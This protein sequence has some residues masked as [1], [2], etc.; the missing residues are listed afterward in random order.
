M[1]ERLDWIFQGGVFVPSV[2]VAPATSGMFPA[3]TTTRV[4]AVGDSLTQ[5]QGAE[6]TGGYRLPLW[7]RMYTN[8]LQF[9][10]VG[11]QTQPPYSNNGNRYY[12]SR[13]SG[14]GGW[15]IGDLMGTGSNNN[16]G[17]AMP[18]WIAE[19]NPSVLLL[20]IGTNDLSETANLTT[21]TTRYT[22]LL[23]QIYTAK[24]DMHI[25]LG[26]I[27]QYQTLSWAAVTNYN[28]M[29]V[30]ELTARVAANP[31]RK[32][33]V[34]NMEP[35]N[36]DPTKYADYVHLNARGYADAADRWYAAITSVPA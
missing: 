12:G 14:Y 23:D 8:G 30:Q 3:G 33:A 9:L 1:P 7:N 24:P 29:C 35:I 32:M 21:L 5:G 26:R 16:T 20:M 15:K 36:Q 22:A 27:P 6:S 31:A 4:M 19:H 13:W 10:P 17:K 2:P 11:Y 25:V 34:A 18:Q 28:N